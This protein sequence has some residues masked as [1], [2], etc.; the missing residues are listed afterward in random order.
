MKKECCIDLY[1]GLLGAGKTTLIRQLLV[2]EYA[3]KKVAIIENEIGRVNLDA[4]LL[5]PAQAQITVREMTGGC[6][7]CTI[8]GAFTE[9]IDLLTEE[10]GPDWQI[11]KDW[12]RPAKSAAVHCCG[13]W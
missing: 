2:T 12:C 13:V 7:C 9:A 10:V 1:A 6:V 3:G 8:R 5:R 4:E 11:W